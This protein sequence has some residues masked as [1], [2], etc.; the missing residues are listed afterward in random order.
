MLQANPDFLAKSA[1]LFHLP[2][3]RSWL[4]DVDDVRQHA[5]KF[6]AEERRQQRIDEQRQAETQIVDLNRI[7]REGA[8]LGVAMNALFDGA[9]RSMYQARLEYT[10]DLLWRSDRLEQAQWAMA[11]A[12]ALAPESAL[13]VEQH[14]FLREVVLQS[15][16]LAVQEELE[17]PASGAPTPELE[18]GGKAQPDYVDDQGFI[19]RKSGLI[20]PR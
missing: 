15:I 11:A 3:C 4:F 20:L 13:P 18:V 12:L 8:L 2:E 19:R 7:Q 5:L 6:I 9:R 14:P 10:A 17:R 16:D 1:D